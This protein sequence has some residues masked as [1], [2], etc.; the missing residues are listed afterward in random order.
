MT[1][2]HAHGKFCF[3]HR[4]RPRLLAPAVVIGSLACAEPIESAV[5]ESPG[6]DTFRLGRVHVL[7]E[8]SAADDAPLPNDE[9]AV[10]A[11]F[12][13]V[14]GL[15]E[16]FVRARVDMPV[17]VSDLLK[18]T[19]CST[20]DALAIDDDASAPGF[21]A[22]GAFPTRELVLVDAGA[23]TVHVGHD[24]LRVPLSL[25]PDLLPYMSGVEYV[26]Y[27]EPVRGI[28]GEPIVRVDA[29]GSQTEAMPPFSVAGVLP[30]EL[31][32][33]FPAEGP[34]EL[35]EDDALVLRW[36]SLGEGPIVFR[37]TPLVGGATIGD[38]VL[39]V[40]D[41]RG[42]ARVELSYLYTLGLAYQ[43]ETI[44]VTASR[45]RVTTFHPGDFTGSELLLERRS[46][47]DIPLR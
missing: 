26:Y 27:G 10:T 43:A 38:D 15:D 17:L 44:R 8:S 1:G 35:A 30:P 36:Q 4:L 41:D 5:E 13:F 32:L 20:E 22:D 18:P 3:V 12:A 39:C 23:L 24:D 37:L 6:L 21:P 42:Q 11:R 45:S 40:F 16:E 9:L 47:I 46:H 14:R 25:V 28:D 29:D 7:A 31:G 19:Q 34:R 2:C 33:E